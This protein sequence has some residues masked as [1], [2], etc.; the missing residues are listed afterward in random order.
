MNSFIEWNSSVYITLGA[1]ALLLAGVG[2]GAV[3]AYAMAQRRKEIGIRMALGAGG[4]RVRRLLL[5]EGSALIAVGLLGGFCAA[6]SAGRVFI[7]TLTSMAPTFAAAARD[8][9]LIA[10]A[11]LLLAA[12]AL[13]ACYLPARRATQVDPVRALRDE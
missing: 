9:L 4:G 12:L 7:A 3:T 6:A 13:T 2:L 11:P 5:R 8:P 10:G 1:F